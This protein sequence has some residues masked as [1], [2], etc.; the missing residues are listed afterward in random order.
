MLAR[1]VRR[2]GN[3]PSRPE[4][5]PQGEFLKKE[6]FK[7]FQLFFFWTAKLLTVTMADE[8]EEKEK[9]SYKRS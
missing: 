7:K 4:F 2:G 3:F 6:I 1:Q 5:L 9:T 8:E